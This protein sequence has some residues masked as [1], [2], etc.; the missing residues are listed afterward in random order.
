MAKRLVIAF[1]FVDEK[2]NSLIG[3]LFN[4]NTVPLIADEVNSLDVAN[5]LMAI[6]RFSLDL[7][8]FPS[9]CHLFPQ[10]PYGISMEPGSK[11]T[12]ISDYIY[13][14]ALHGHTPL[15]HLPEDDLHCGL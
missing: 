9:V 2:N 1:D 7:Q 15:V 14:E 10:T 5:I 13:S 3:D 4:S 8:R 12:D 11:V 6:Y